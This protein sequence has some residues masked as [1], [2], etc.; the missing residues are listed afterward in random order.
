[1]PV[2]AVPVSVVVPV[3]RPD[4]ALSAQLGAIAVQQHEGDVEVVLAANGV[5]PSVLR[6]FVDATEWP[7]GWAVRVVDATDVRGPSHARNVGWRAAR[8][9]IVLFCDADDVL[10]PG[11]ISAMAAAVQQDGIGGGR[12][13]YDLLNAPALAA[14]VTASTTELP[15]KFRHLPYTP[16]CAL[17]V[18]R[19]L[20]EAVD[21]FDE[22]LHCGEDIDF[23]WR[24]AAAGSPIV[25]VPQAVVQYRLRSAARGAF[26]QAYRYGVD[27]ARLLRAHRAA[28]ARWRAVDGVRELAST[29]KA[30][31]LAGTGQEARITAASRVGATCGRFAGSVRHRIAAF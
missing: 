22:S 20:L 29:V 27:D 26:R 16:S 23:C 8:H 21:G 14:R 1:M 17:G 15:V 9:D 4:T 28:G 25:F 7:S 31:L 12:L 24:V 3:G 10:E 18:T 2:S 11:W 6:P 13:A 5:R 30:V 19:A